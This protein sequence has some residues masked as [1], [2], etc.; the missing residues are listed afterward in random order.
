VLNEI[1]DQL[2][3]S[4][5]ADRNE[6]IAFIEAAQSRIVDLC[7]VVKQYYYHPFFGGS[8]SIKAVLPAILRCNDQLRDKYSQPIGAILLTSLNFSEDHTWISA[9]QINPYQS[10]PSIKEGG[11]AMAAY[12]Q[13]MY[14]MSTEIYAQ[15]LRQGLLK[16]CEL[17]T[18]AMVMLYEHLVK[19]TE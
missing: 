4:N 5:E 18:L 14:T 6:L 10:L 1:K 12:A 17:D 19:E 16:Y 8:N 15:E 2:E 13:L 7:K 11:A 9:N 3:N